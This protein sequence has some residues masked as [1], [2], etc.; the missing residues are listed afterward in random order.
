MPAEMLE[1]TTLKR[2]RECALNLFAGTHAAGADDAFGRIETEIRIGFVL[3]GIKVIGTGIA[4][5]HLAKPH[6]ARHILQLAIA[7]GSAGQ[8]V[9]RMIGDVKLHDIAANLLQL[10]GLGGHHH[11]LGNGSGAGCRQAVAALDL[12][13]A[14]PAGA[15]SLQ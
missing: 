15:V 14:K 7:I 1:T 6:R 9:Q 8:T 5:A 4:I 13:K 10:A 3:C 12:H 2:Q 11:A